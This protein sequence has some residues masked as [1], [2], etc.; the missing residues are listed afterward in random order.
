MSLAPGRS[1]RRTVGPIG[2][3]QEKV[4][5]AEKAGATDFLVPAANCGD[6]VGLRTELNLVKVNTLREA[7][8]A[9]QTLNTPGRP[10]CCRLLMPTWDSADACRRLLD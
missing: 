6:L 5:G 9:L 8:T 4:A 3:I 1:R 2:G 10:T 7:I